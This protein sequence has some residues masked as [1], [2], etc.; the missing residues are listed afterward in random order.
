MLPEYH[1]RG[2]Y[3]TTSHF[4]KKGKEEERKWIIFSVVKSGE[5]SLERKREETWT[6]CTLVI[7]GQIWGREWRLG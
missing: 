2:M 6:R 7:R 1:V 4:P 3:S 5:V